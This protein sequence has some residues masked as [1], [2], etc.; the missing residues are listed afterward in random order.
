[1]ERA[2]VEAIYEQGREFV[3]AMLLRMDE[4]IA[5][6][7]K[8]VAQQDERIARLERAAKRSSRNSSQPP[9]QDPPTAPKRGKD[10]SG[11]KP[12]GQP[13][14]EGKGRP[15]LPAWAIDEVVEHWPAACSCGRVFSVAERIA[16]S[17]PR[18]TR[19]RSCR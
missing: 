18:A 19:S 3:V 14:G 7:E 16:V 15:L 1:V 2:E 8:R 6:L 12:G 4:Q 17:E 9:S 5:R 11:R 10:P 13:G